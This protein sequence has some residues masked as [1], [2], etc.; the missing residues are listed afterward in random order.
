MK[1]NH[2]NPLNFFAL[3]VFFLINSAA[4]YAQNIGAYTSSLGPLSSSQG[5]QIVLETEGD[6][7]TDD[8]IE[9]FIKSNSGTSSLRVS[10]FQFRVTE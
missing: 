7:V 4:A 5:F 9:V 8:Y 3:L 2:L 10:D 1:K 6:L